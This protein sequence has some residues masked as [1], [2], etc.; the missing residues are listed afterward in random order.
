MKRLLKK[1]DIWSWKQIGCIIAVIGALQFIIMSSLAM[2]FYPGG[3]SFFNDYLSHLG[4]TEVDGE[5]NTISFWL[6]IFATNVAGLTLI[7]IWF[8]IKTLFTKKRTETILS[9]FGT[10]LGVISGPF[11]MAIGVFPADT[12]PDEHGIVTTIFF[13]LFAMAIAIYSIAI[14]Y[15]A[16]YPNPY[17]YVGVIF[18]IVIVLFIGGLFAP[19]NV[20][21]QKIIVYGFVLWVVFQVTKVWDSVN[22]PQA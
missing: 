16:D 19:I 21:M 4:Q 6:W 18:S 11:L 13:L 2:I 14:L 5:P 1:G 20:A 7:P 9:M 8:V 10:V 15:N 22:L 3:Y 17:A 12:R